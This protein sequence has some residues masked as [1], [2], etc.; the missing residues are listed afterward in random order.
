MRKGFRWTWKPRRRRIAWGGK[1]GVRIETPRG[2]L[3]ARAVIVAVPVGVLAKD[4][5][6]FDPLLPDWKRQAIDDLPMGSC[7]K[8]ALA[9]TRDVFG[10]LRTR[11]MI[12]IS[13]LIARSSSWC[14]RAGTTSSPP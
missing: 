5:I 2:T 6:R 14:A 10:D 9:F 11:G 4:M 3:E 7:N 12:P 1:N 8:V 13:A